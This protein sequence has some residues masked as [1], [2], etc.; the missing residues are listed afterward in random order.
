MLIFDKSDNKGKQRP[1][2]PVEAESPAS[3]AP[4]VTEE[5]ALESKPKPSEQKVTSKR[6][7][8]PISFGGGTLMAI[9]ALI[10]IAIGT[11]ALLLI[12]TVQDSMAENSSVKDSSVVL[13]E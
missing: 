4:K 11:G 12:T 10:F 2:K 8:T 5:N 3:R 6:A 1:L 9:A 13:P 7:K